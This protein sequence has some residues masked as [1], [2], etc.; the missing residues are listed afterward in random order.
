MTNKRYYNYLL[1]LFLAIICFTNVEAQVFDYKAL[2]TLPELTLEQ[3]LK[4]D[5]LTVYKLTLKKTKLIDLPESILAFKNLQSL[6]ISKN[7][8][9][10]FPVLIFK[11]TYLQKLDI[12]DNKIKTIPIEIGT[13]IYLK[14]FIANQTDIATL[15]VEIGKLKELVYLDIWGTNI[16]S[17]PEEIQQLNETLNEIDMRVIMMSDAE[18]KKIKELLP[19]TKI[20]FSKSCN[21]GF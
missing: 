2:D 19:N 3:A 6:D 14:Q 7:K 17:F 18:H 12:S 9:S 5:P 10:H 15:P 20:H 11:Y 16:A 21:C 13:L 4:K 8:F 1:N